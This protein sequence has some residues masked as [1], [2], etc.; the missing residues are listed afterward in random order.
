MF[1]VVEIGGNQYTVKVGDQ[2]E[3]DRLAD[4]QNKT[5]EVSP[6]LVS[7]EAGKTSVGTPVLTS[8]KVSLKVVEHAKGDKIDVLR[9]K[10]KKHYW[11]ATGF[12]AAI[13]K[14]EVL[15]IA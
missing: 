6:L 2:I 15:S 11:R 3:V 12:R 5:I 10:A 1:A 8:N 13:T 14:L 7:D 4:E 9:F